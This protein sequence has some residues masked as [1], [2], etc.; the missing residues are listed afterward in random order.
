VGAPLMIGVAGIRGIV[1]ESLT[2]EVVSR[3]AA[4]F[5]RGL[6]R[7]AVIVGRD[8]RPSGAAVYHAVAAGVMGAGRD[9]IDLGLATTPTTEIAVEHLRGAGGIVLTASHNPAPWNALKFLSA[10]GE[11]LGPRAGLKVRARFDRGRDLWVG[12]PRLGA[13]AREN[14]ALDWHLERVLSLPALDLE[15]I[16]ARALTVAVDGCASVGGL[17]VPRLLERLGARVIEVDCVPNGRF[18]RE[19]EPLP[20]HLGRLGDA[21][22]AGGADFGVALDPD[23]DR[24][25]LVDG[26][27]TP[28][29]EEY[30]VALGTQVV[31]SRRRGPV[32]TNLSTSRIV[33]A[34]CE[35]AAV[36]LYRSPVGEAH[37]VAMMRA[38]GA[39][40]GGE[41]NGGMIVPDAHFGRDGLVATALVAQALA[42]SGRN[43][44][45]LADDLPRLH[46]LKTK[47]PRPDESW[48][49]IDAR[50]TRAF[51]GHARRTLDGLHLS[52]ADEWVHVRASG[53]EPVVRV[54]AESPDPA[55][56]RALV[57]T[58]RAAL[59]GRGAGRSQRAQ[60]RG[61]TRT[62]KG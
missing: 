14:A 53:T 1:G 58:A 11:F 25:A 45:E 41:G 57:A 62:R 9:V 34:V 10:R 31:L 22:R 29:G 35:R 33:D 38:R 46:M 26:T 23:A 37:V 39:V 27:G 13:A 32:V 43:V 61:R 60:A 18:T 24:A 56:T 2:P 44:R 40:A 20:E 42:A 21:V 12:A 50:L 8:A 4:A 47:L 16:R 19:L 52:H 5:A 30:T 28:L 7:G 49:R 54:I 48:E 15:R 17:A 55:R 51:K 59:A 36:P 3:F 6:E